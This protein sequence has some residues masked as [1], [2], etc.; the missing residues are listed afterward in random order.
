MDERTMFDTTQAAQDVWR[1]HAATIFPGD[2]F[3]AAS[4]EEYGAVAVHV[5][6]ETSD[7]EHRSFTPFACG[8]S[9]CLSMYRDDGADEFLLYIGESCGA[10][11]F[12][13]TP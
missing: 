13:W 9:E 7:G 8:C 6:I 1:E 4:T 5:E 2:T 10:R 11:D 3:L 12:D